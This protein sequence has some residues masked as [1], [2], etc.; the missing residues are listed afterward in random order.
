MI[1]ERTKAIL[2]LTSYLSKELDKETKP[3]AINEWN[4]IV[5][6]MQSEKLTPEALLSSDLDNILQTWVGSKVSKKRV[7]DLLDRKMALALKLEKW[8][9]AGVWII[10][11]SDSGYPE[12][13]KN[14]LKGKEPPI[15]FGIGDKNLLSQDYIGIVGSRKIDEDD[16][17]STRQI[18]GQIHSQGFGVVSG[19]AK[20]ID[21][22]SMTGILDQGGFALGVLAESLIKKSTDG[23]YRRFIQGNK[24]VLISPFN[25]E[26]G[27]NV[28]N[29]MARNKLIYILSKATIVVKSEIKGGTWE[30]ADENLKQKWVPLWVNE[31][32]DPKSAKGNQE[33]VKKGGKWLPKT[34]ESS[35]LIKFIPSVKAHQAS[36][37]NSFSESNTETITQVNEPIIHFEP[38]R[39]PSKSLPNGDKIDFISASFYD[40]F[41]YKV[42]EKIGNQPFTKEQLLA[43]F[44]LTSKQLDEWLK[45]GEERK[46]LVKKT[47]PVCYQLNME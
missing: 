10:N 34:F 6:W 24:L 39:D 36:L 7:I 17:S 25:P 31:P 45:M 18:V 22:H 41:L 43:E 12:S 27:F 40:F 15:L 8:T 20:G 11:R 35:D 13:L 14:S 29:A 19:G 4:E 3:L 44:D 33:I 1:S 47:R 30:G 23:M 28:G 16:I 2:L 38:I 42:S 32:S 37:F 46:N 9:K 21:E 26:A 5:R